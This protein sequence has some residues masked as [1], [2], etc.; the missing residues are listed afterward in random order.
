MK[1]NPARTQTLIAIALVMSGCANANPPAGATGGGPS[2]TG[3]LAFDPLE[4][5]STDSPADGGATVPPPCTPL[6]AKT[7]RA[8][9]FLYSCERQRFLDQ[10]YTSNHAQWQ[11]LRG[12]AD[13]S[14][15]ATA[16]YDDIGGYAALAYQVTGDVGY[17][18]KGGHQA[19]KELRKH[20]GFDLNYTRAKWAEYA[21]VYDWLKGGM[22]AADELEMRNAL[23][24]WATQFFAR[25]P[26]T[27][28]RTADTDQTTG[29]YFGIMLTALA[30]KGD[31]PRAD[32]L[33]VN[34]F[35]GGFDATGSDLTTLRNA[36]HKYIT[37]WAQGG[38]WVESAYYDVETLQLLVQG[39]EA[40]R[41]ATGVDHFPEFA[42]F[43][44]Q[45]LLAQMTQLTPDFLSAAKWGDVEDA[46]DVQ[47]WR[48]YQTLG[49]Y[50]GTL[51]WSSPLRAIG[52]QFVNDLK[53]KYATDLVYQ[54]RYYYYFDPLGPAADWRPA[55]AKTH[56]AA[57]QG[58]V[59]AHDSWDPDGSLVHMHFRRPEMGIDH[60]SSQFGDFSLYRKGGWAVT[61]PLGYGGGAIEPV[62]VNAMVLAGLDAMSIRSTVGQSAASDGSYVYFAGNTRGPRYA[63]SYYDP[64]PAFVHEWT[65]SFFYLPSAGKT[66]DTIIIHD[67]VD[68]DAPTRIDRFR[69]DDQARIA[70]APKRKQF[71]VHAL[72]M[73]AVTSTG[74]TWTAAAQRVELTTL[75]PAAHTKRIVDEKTLGWPASFPVDSEK[76]Y[77]VSVSPPTEQSWDTFLDVIQASDGAIVQKPVRIA[78]NDGG[79]EGALVARPGSRDALALFSATRGARLRGSSFRFS[80]SSGP[81]GMDIYIADLDPAKP[82]TASPGGLLTLDGGGVAHL[83][84]PAGAVTVAIETP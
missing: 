47:A 35:V 14:D 75:A 15:T 36:V 7:A 37:E 55:L 17:A 21:I 56:H 26:S 82:W 73:P 57:G 2:A 77:Y 84:V 74:A 4:P 76:H 68:A 46:R 66:V 12:F 72:T 5:S 59:F 42:G 50:V 8:P 22:D 13:R 27:P 53:Q 67:R 38:V 9:R 54:A 71:I 51:A 30:T 23:F 65:R 3:V 61:H 62:A 29:N 33:L 45:V 25:D 58:M 41:T 60:E 20:L 48:R 39:V 43:N 1:Q 34:P 11:E 81:A 63:G 32:A 69:A 18:V 78:S 31:D 24:G 16:R 79:M 80:A 40:M 49:M 19:L 52:T 70:A 10:L 83:V 6:A 44:E 64:P 28:I